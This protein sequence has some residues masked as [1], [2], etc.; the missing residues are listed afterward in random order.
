MPLRLHRTVKARRR[1]QAS[2]IV[3]PIDILANGA[4][5]VRTGRPSRCPEFRLECAEEAFGD[6]VVV[7][8]AA[9]THAAPRAVRGQQHLIR[10]AGVLR[11]PGPSDEGARD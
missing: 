3:E 6:G 4:S 2:W 11:L 5:G 10:R 8:I 9:T 1:M 7:T